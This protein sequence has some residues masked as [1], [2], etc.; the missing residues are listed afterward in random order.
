M[1]DALHFRPATEADIPAMSRI[2]IAVRENR[3]SDPTR[4]TEAMYRDHLGPLGRSWVAELGGEVI[5]FS[6]AARADA[7]IWA[8]FTD[9]A[10]EGLGAGKRLLQLAVDWLFSEGAQE[11]QLGTAANTRADRFYAA[12]GWQRQA[13][14]NEIEVEYRLPRP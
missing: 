8:L 11:V 2:R 3:L 13:M 9:P 6:S 10:H 7:S 1:T 14:R 5:A 4:I 12:Q